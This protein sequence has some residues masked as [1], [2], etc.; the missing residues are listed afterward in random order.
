[1]TPSPLLLSSLFSLVHL[2]L[3]LF[4]HFSS[5]LFFSILFSLLSF[6][7]LGLVTSL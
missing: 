1:M 7:V 4:V 2:K 3:A 5:S 6:F